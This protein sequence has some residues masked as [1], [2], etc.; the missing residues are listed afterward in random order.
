MW[1]S[2]ILTPV[3]VIVLVTTARSAE[4]GSVQIG[5]TKPS[6]QDL[7]GVDGKNHS[8]VDLQDK[9]IIVIAITCNHCPIA[10]EYFE[11]LKQFS[12][13]QCGPKSDVA[14]VA[15]SISHMESDKLEQMKELS[16]REGFNFPYL[17]DES[18]LIGKAL[19]AAVTPQF[20]VLD[21]NRTLVY[22]GPWDDQINHTKVKTHYVED[23][24]AALRNGKSPLVA[25]VHSTG[26][27]IQYER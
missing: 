26:C 2:R 8:L 1:G 27:A 11:R 13:E 18:Q 19:G 10:R 5:H 6:W 17:R 25:D 16:Q 14:L 21:R 23:A 4:P 9:K 22:R 12:Q 7:P 3:L 15:I 24:V 20:F